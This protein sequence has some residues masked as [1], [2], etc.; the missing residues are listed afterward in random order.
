MQ[1]RFGSNLPLSCPLPLLLAYAVL[2]VLSVMS[3][4]VLIRLHVMQLN[5]IVETQLSPPPHQ[6]RWKVKNSIV[7][8]LAG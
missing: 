8:L 3:P 4:R 2:S 6:N 7:L 1:S 5:W